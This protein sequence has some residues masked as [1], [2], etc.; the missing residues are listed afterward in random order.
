MRPR[1][2]ITPSA[3]LDFSK[4]WVLGWGE[5]A[6]FKVS[7][8]EHGQGKEMNQDCQRAPDNGEIRCH[9]LSDLVPPATVTMVTG[10]TMA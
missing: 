8:K 3:G 2:D 5:A 6:N 1:R 10:P 7:G 9:M 4:D